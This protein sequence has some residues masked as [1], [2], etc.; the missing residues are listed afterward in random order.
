MVIREAQVYYG[1]QKSL[2]P[3]SCAH[4]LKQVTIDI[5]LKGV[6]IYKPEMSSSSKA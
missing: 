3:T 2:D 4:Q 6:L 1:K 5:S